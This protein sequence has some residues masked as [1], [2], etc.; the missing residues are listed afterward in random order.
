M[1]GLYVH[2]PYC[3][4]KCAYCDFYSGPLRGFDAEAYVAATMTELETRR[5][6]VLNIGEQFQTLY[7][8]GGTPS[9]IDPL[10]LARFCDLATETA[11]KTIE[12]NPEDVIPEWACRAHSAGFNRV[13]M[14]VQSLNDDELRSVGRRHD[15]NRAFDAFV[16]LREAG[17][18]N[19]SLDLIYGLPGQTLQSWVKSLEGVIGLRPEHISAYMLSYE[20]GTNLHT[21]LQAGKIKE[22]DE[23]TLMEMYN[24]LCEL[25]RR[26]GYNHYEISNFALEDR[27]SRHNSSYWD[28]TPYLGLGPGA[29][30][31]DGKL[32]R[33]NPSN[34]KGYMKN[35]GGS[36]V[37]ESP[38][39]NSL[40]NDRIITGL[41]TSKGLS[42]DVFNSRELTLAEQLL[43][44]TDSGFF[45][46]AEEQWLLSNQIMEAFIR[47]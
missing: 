33:Y 42:P 46:I 36:F 3:A 35:P 7:I 13:S 26:A 15:S 28:F 34:L 24:Q 29:H 4:A 25:T 5:A 39:P 45:R 21:R 2:I 11:E 47:I 12:V 6:E 38:E 41:R 18:L 9:S 30:S 16:T 40:Y 22:T 44:R 1:A 8:G 37:V 14:G 23:P 31:F 32:R 27:H 10:L 20:P 43:Q 19:I 17:F